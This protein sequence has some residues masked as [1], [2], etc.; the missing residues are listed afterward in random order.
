MTILSKNV[1]GGSLP[2]Y[3]SSTL[4]VKNIMA[5]AIITICGSQMSYGQDQW[6]REMLDGNP[7]A[8]FNKATEIQILNFEGQITNMDEVKTNP[9]PLRFAEPHYLFGKNYD[10]INYSAIKQY[11]DQLSSES[12]EQ[13]KSNIKYFIDNQGDDEA[14][15]IFTGFL[16]GIDYYLANRSEVNQSTTLFI[17]PRLHDESKAFSASARNT[18]LDYNEN[19][20]TLSD[21]IKSNAQFKE[22]TYHHKQ[23]FNYLKTSGL[24]PE[25][26]ALAL[27]IETPSYSFNEA[28][29]SIQKKYETRG[30]FVILDN[31]IL[32][33]VEHIEEGLPRI[34]EVKRSAVSKL[35]VAIEGLDV[36]KTYSVADLVKLRDHKGFRGERI[37]LQPGFFALT[38]KIKAYEAGGLT[39]KISGLNGKK[40][41]TKKSPVKAEKANIPISDEHIHKL[42]RAEQYIN[43]LRIL[44]PTI[45][46]PKTYTFEDH[47]GAFQRAKV[48]CL[49]HL[50]ETG[51]QDSQK[52]RIDLYAE[53][54]WERNNAFDKHLWSDWTKNCIR[55]YIE[56]TY[57]G[58]S[59]Q[60][61]K[62]MRVFFDACNGD[63]IVPTGTFDR[64][65]DF[66]LQLEE[67]F[68]VSFM[69]YH[70]FLYSLSADS[71]SLTKL[72][73]YRQG[74]TYPLEPETVEECFEYLSKGNADQSF[75]APQY[76]IL[77][78]LWALIKNK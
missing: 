74:A 8:A 73:G 30:P 14:L 27:L 43:L 64:D 62:I 60:H 59:G 23:D 41:K 6:S 38:E 46:D 69:P 78:R 25:L 21:E 39:L 20:L 55:N 33:E 56:V 58:K 11:Y 53:M 18:F 5:M 49:V 65:Y 24:L 31:H 50:N 26:S 68:A 61:G 66:V 40:E 63:A 44:A 22:M 3:M 47:S 19:Q 37:V 2:Q 52:C 57:P 35:V 77:C 67:G 48:P 28:K 76:R 17:S 45:A 1:W 54:G 12:R 29:A 10:S 15:I 51:R 75:L 16:H 70:S 13:I 42:L 36:N 4:F 32:D 9:V 7:I 71:F 34:L 72:I